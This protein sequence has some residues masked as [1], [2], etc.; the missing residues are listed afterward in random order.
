MEVAAGKHVAQAAEAV[1]AHQGDRGLREG[2]VE[3]CVDVRS[4]AAVA[5]LHGD[6]KLAACVP[7]AVVAD[8]VGV[9][10]AAHHF[11]L[12]RDVAKVLAAVHLNDLDGAFLFGR[13]IDCAVYTPE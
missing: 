11:E 1:A 7:A 13:L 6:E 2:S 3:V 4:R 10:A 5:Q 9:A 12:H 8:D